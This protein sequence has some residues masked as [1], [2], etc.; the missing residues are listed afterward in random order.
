MAGTSLTGNAQVANPGWYTAGN[1]AGNA[2]TMA[3][4][5]GA[6]KGLGIGSQATSGA[7]LTGTIGG[8]HS[9]ANQDW[10]K[11]GQ[12]AL[13]MAGDVIFNAAVGYTGGKV[14]EMLDD[15]I[16]RIWYESDTVKPAGSLKWPESEQELVATAGV[17]GYTEGAGKLNPKDIK[18]PE[19]NSKWE[20]RYPEANKPNAKPRWFD[21]NGGEW[22][23]HAPDKWHPEGHW[24]YNPWDT[25]NSKWQNIYPD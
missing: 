3:L 1:I 22:R 15:V 2:A 17:S 16:K 19:W 8:A 10:S 21:P 20:W 14:A 7:I 11:P 9:A 24:D 4:G 6:L 5:A 18:P 25:W 23:W 13:N 12:A